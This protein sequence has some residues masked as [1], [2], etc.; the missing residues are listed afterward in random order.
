MIGRMPVDPETLRDLL[1][2]DDRHADIIHAGGRK[3]R[4]D[5]TKGITLDCNFSQVHGVAFECKFPA[6]S[7][8]TADFAAFQRQHG[9]R[10]KDSRGSD[11]ERSRDDP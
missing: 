9:R 8:S 1:G 4:G 6:N 3:W 2:V 10:V 11:V 7:Q 5:A